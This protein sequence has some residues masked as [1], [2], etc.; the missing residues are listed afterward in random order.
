MSNILYLP[1]KY[2]KIDGA[3]GDEGEVTVEKWCP[4]EWGAK[5]HVNGKFKQDIRIWNEFDGLKYLEIERRREW[6]PDFQGGV[7]PFDWR[8]EVH[9]PKRRIISMDRLFITLR[10]DMKVGIMIFPIDLKHARTVYVPNRKQKDG[11]PEPFWVVDYHRC[12]PI[13]FSYTSTM[14]FT[15]L[16]KNRVEN[17]IRTKMRQS[18]LMRVLGQFPPYGMDEDTWRWHLKRLGLMHR[19]AKHLEPQDGDQNESNHPSSSADKWGHG[20]GHE[21]GDGAQYQQ[22]PKQNLEYHKTFLSV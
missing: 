13:D 19:I 15:I 4:N 8:H 17:A 16:N 22:N 11:K 2:S 14:P 6:L 21:C 18:S 1:V 3:F 7:F 12:L 10:I 9:V 20:I 5:R